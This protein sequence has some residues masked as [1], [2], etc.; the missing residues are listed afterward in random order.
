[1]RKYLSWLLATTL[2][3]VLATAGLVSAAPAPE[4]VT[5]QI[6]GAAVPYYAPLYVAKEKG[7]FA[8]E[9]LDVDFYYAAAADIVKNVAVGNVEFGFP[10]ADAVILAKSQ[11]IPVKVIH[12]TY[13]RGLGATIFKKSSGIKEPKDLKGKRVAITS[14]GS[15]NY[16]Q[17]QV[18]LKK[19]GLSVKDVKIE[20]VGTGAIVNALA[21]DQVDAIC[22]SMLRTFELRNRGVD[23]AEFR[24]DEFLPSHGNVLVTSE[25]LLRE[26]PELA[27]KFIRALDKSLKWIIGGHLDEAINL[28]VQKYAPTYAGQEK[29]LEEIFDKA[30]INYLWQ[31]D[32]TRAHGLGW[33]DVE[34]WQRSIDV[35]KEYGV[36]DKAFDAKTLVTNEFLK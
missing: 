14:Y 5:I 30:F 21:T 33:G 7:F 18:L 3:L 13:Q 9:G 22:F 12:T 24:S 1:M 28:A 15:P 23:V 36:I 25:K 6:D 32:N 4:K 26:K 31:S 16:I 20:I 11:G 34:R 27:R 2:L 8:E 29:S 10:N 17:L 19:A 35:M